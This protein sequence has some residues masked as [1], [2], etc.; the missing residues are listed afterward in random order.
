MN[1]TDFLKGV[2]DIDDELVTAPKP[3]G[4]RSALRYA[5]PIAACALLCAGIALAVHLNKPA[6]E[7]PKEAALPQET[8]TGVTETPQ[9]T[10]SPT[11]A[12]RIVYADDAE[13][14]SDQWYPTPGQINYTSPL[15]PT[16]NGEVEGDWDDCLFAV[17]I[18]LTHA[19]HGLLEQKI[20]EEQ[21][22]L[23][24]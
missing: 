24:D 14:A 8:Q 17:I 1:G 19:D 13:T 12:P 2:N 4:R 18:C 23:R 10:V 21:L 5:L 6:A 15:W 11:E 3:A 20:H 22:L 16:I 9:E 7:D